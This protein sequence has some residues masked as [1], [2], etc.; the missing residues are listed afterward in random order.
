MA[1]SE[2]MSDARLA[3]IRRL[4]DLFES[5]ERETPEQ[6]VASRTLYAARIASAVPAL[7]AEVERLRALLA[8][9]EQPH[10]GG[11]DGDGR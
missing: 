6:T 9:H 7:L 11:G 10:A 8:A 2:P 5:D 1:N 3:E 4:S